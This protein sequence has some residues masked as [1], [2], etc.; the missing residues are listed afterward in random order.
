MTKKN[1]IAIP[2]D[3]DADF[4]N[5]RE[6]QD[7]QDD[8]FFCTFNSNGQL[9]KLP[10][11]AKNFSKF[12][13]QQIITNFLN[14]SLPFITFHDFNPFDLTDDTIEF[15]D[16]RF[17]QI[18]DGLLEREIEIPNDLGFKK[19][20]FSLQSKDDHYY[21]PGLPPLIY[22]SY[23]FFQPDLEESYEYNN[24]EIYIKFVKPFEKLLKEKFF[25]LNNVKNNEVLDH[26]RDILQYQSPVNHSNYFSFSIYQ[27]SDVFMNKIFEPIS[28]I[29]NEIIHTEKSLKQYF[30]KEDL[31]DEYKPIINKDSYTSLKPIG[32]CG[33]SA[34]A[35]GIMDSE[36]ELLNKLIVHVEMVNLCLGIQEGYE[37]YF[38]TNK[39]NFKND[40]NKISGSNHTKLDNFIKRFSK[41]VAICLNSKTNRFIITDY[42]WTGFFQ[43]ENIKDGEIEDAKKFIS[44]VKVNHFGFSNFEF[45]NNSKLTTRNLIASFFN[46]NF[47]DL[48]IINE[49]F[50][51]INKKVI[52]DWNSFL[53]YD[54]SLIIDGPKRKKLKPSNKLSN[55]IYRTL[56]GLSFT[57][58]D[59]DLEKSL[60]K[61]IAIGSEWSCQT[62]LCDISKLFI[63]K[64]Y[65]PKNYN[66]NS[67][68]KFK[69]VLISIYDEYYQDPSLSMISR[70]LKNQNLKYGSTQSM[71]NA[72]QVF[73]RWISNVDAYSRLIKLQGDLIAKVLDYGYL[74]DKPFNDQ[75]GVHFKCDGYYII[76]EPISPNDEDLI[77]LDGQNDL[78]YELAK[79]TLQKL[80]SNG[81]TFHP[82][83][84][85]IPEVIKI[86]NNKAY[87]I[88]LEET[89][90]LIISN[91]HI[92]KDLI[93]LDKIFNKKSDLSYLNIKPINSN[94]SNSSSNKKNRRKSSSLIDNLNDRIFRYQSTRRRNSNIADGIINIDDFNDI[95][96]DNAD[97]FV[98]ED[99]ED[100]VY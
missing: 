23:P 15:I 69:P 85:L 64:N 38:N 95:D 34:Y 98:L 6:N 51:L 49:N 67:L 27:F 26:L 11:F 33:E 22:E 60:I 89:N 93:A 66:L 25:K 43:I 30:P 37:L 91:S 5:I 52:E 8:I 45:Q 14:T 58:Q 32:S 36:T 29:Y 63:D 79:S 90:S 71:D 62:I 2:L 75:N 59:V 31:N 81:V 70:H 3:P 57:K 94:P 61:F 53:N 68:N 41:C 12:N 76:Y 56:D 13:N 10:K 80:H 99:D 35:F 18:T 7:D 87:I 1:L 84:Q 54:Q 47:K 74:E 72:E 16:T 42:Y 48:K 92:K 24:D 20:R 97:Y 17:Y 82:T 21:L 100:E 55:F 88:N 28:I 77:P 86:Y 78:H 44:K 50:D 40:D 46:V 96:E 83:S 39:R 4:L 73:Q 9:K 19:Q 65:I